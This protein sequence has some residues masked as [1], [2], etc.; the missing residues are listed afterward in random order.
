M[1]LGDKLKPLLVD[2]VARALI[3]AAAILNILTWGL[4]ATRLLPLVVKGGIIALHY[5]VYLKVN[6]VGLAT[7]AFL[8][9]GIG[10]VILVLNAFL[11]AKAYTSSRILALALLSVT[12]FYELLALL[13]GVFIILINI[14]R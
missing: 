11:A 5:N 6:D 3:L 9:A 2:R 12:V 8:P 7:W 1:K 13:A 4:L 10:L 14:S